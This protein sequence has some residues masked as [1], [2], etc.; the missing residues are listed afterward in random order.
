MIIRF[1]RAIRF[2]PI[3]DVQ[4]VITQ[5]AE[6]TSCKMSAASNQIGEIIPPLMFDL[7]ILFLES[8]SKMWE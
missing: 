1:N 5:T 7:T 4:F 3:T 2:V 8:V 6:M